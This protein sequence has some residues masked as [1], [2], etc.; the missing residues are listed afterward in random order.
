MTNIVNKNDVTTASK[1]DLSKNNKK[2]GILLEGVKNVQITNNNINVDS[3][4]NAYGIYLYESNNNV[5]KNN[6]EYAAKYQKD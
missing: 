1:D 4:D 2:F 3:Y 6:V 5:I